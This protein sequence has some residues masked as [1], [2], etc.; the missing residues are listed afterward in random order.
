[1]RIAHIGLWK[2]LDGSEQNMVKVQE[3]IASFKGQ[4]AG[5]LESSASPMIETP[6][7]AASIKAFGAGDPSQLTDGYNWALYMIFDSKESRAAYEDDPLHASV[8][9]YLMPSLDG[10]VT[11]SI[12][13]AD[14]ELPD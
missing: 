8:A 14:F 9:P 13:Q 11:N 4:I 5:C 7:S 1:M 10:P 12:L 2:I 6:R 3:I